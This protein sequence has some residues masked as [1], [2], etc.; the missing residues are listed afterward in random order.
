MKAVLAKRLGVRLIVIGITTMQNVTELLT[1]IASS[2]LNFYR[3]DDLR[4]HNTLATQLAKDICA[5]LRR[6]YY[7]LIRIRESIGFSSLLSKAL[8]KHSAITCLALPLV[9]FVP[10]F[11]RFMDDHCSCFGLEMQ[12]CAQ[13]TVSSKPTV[14]TDFALPVRCWSSFRLLVPRIL[15]FTK[16]F[17]YL[18][19]LCL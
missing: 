7:T 18:R 16:Q 14:L 13:Q 19:L 15:S 12:P 10:M 2:T 3:V 9:A 6:F 5:T 1:D 17:S 4:D 8:K 11:D